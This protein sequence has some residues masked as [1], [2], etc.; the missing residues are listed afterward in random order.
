MSISIL[1]SMNLLQSFFS[2]MGKFNNFKRLRSNELVMVELSLFPSKKK[3][4]QDK[5][6][7]KWNAYVNK[8]AINPHGCERLG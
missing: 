8:W 2:K 5:I 6:E 3:R 1:T 4:P 7:V